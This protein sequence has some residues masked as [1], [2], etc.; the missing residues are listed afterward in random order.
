[1]Q[2]L[3]QGALAFSLRTFGKAYGWSQAETGL[4][5]MKLLR[6]IVSPFHGFFYP[7]TFWARLMVVGPA[8]LLLF[9]NLTES[10]VLGVTSIQFQCLQSGLCRFCFRCW[11]AVG[12]GKCWSIFRL[13]C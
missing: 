9:W 10:S 7:I 2:S 3:L 11:K 12:L 8:N 13:D 1:M 6:D 5:L 4:F